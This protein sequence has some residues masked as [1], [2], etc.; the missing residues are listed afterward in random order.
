MIKKMFDHFRQV[1]PG[2]KAVFLENYDAELGRLITSGVD[3]WLNTPQKPW[4]ASGTSGMK[5][6]H[7]GVPSLST[8]DGWWIEGF[9]DGVTGWAIES[10]ADTIQDESLDMYNKLEYIILPMFYKN[11]EKWIDIMQQSISVNASYFNTQRMV[12]EYIL[13]AYFC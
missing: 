10:D 7:N 5:A 2:I 6:A 11:R 1:K 9:I 13:D 12:Q 4:E 3:L 8:L